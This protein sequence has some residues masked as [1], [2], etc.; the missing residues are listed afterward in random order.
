M[1]NYKLDR[2]NLW[3][4]Q[5]SDH[6]RELTVLDYLRYNHLWREL[7]HKYDKM[8]YFVGILHIYQRQQGQARFSGISPKLFP[9]PIEY[10]AKN[11]ELHPL[12]DI[13]WACN[14][15]DQHR[16]RRRR[17]NNKKWVCDGASYLYM[18][19]SN[20]DLNRPLRKVAARTRNQ[21]K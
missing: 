16:W 11:A 12:R 20:S 1:W 13:L 7:Y 17:S 6:D 18:T 5:S 19:A 4:C 21:H 9:L 10:F 3:L 15:W 14:Q 2:P 8:K